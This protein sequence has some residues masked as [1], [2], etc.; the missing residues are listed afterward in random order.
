[1]R[2]RDFQRRLARGLRFTGLTMMAGSLTAAGLRSDIPAAIAAP[3]QALA[4][5]AAQ[6]LPAA[7]IA[8]S[9]GSTPAPILPSTPKPSEKAASRGGPLTF[10]MSGNLALGEHML[11]SSFAGSDTG[12]TGQSQTEGNAGILLQLSRRTGSTMTQLNV[13]LGVTSSGP[14]RLGFP[15]IT[16]ATPKVGLTYQAQPLGLLGQIPLGSTLSGFGVIVPFA[17]GDLTTFQGP[18]AIEDGLTAR[19]AGIRARKTTGSTI[20]EAGYMQAASESTPEREGLALFGFSHASGPLDETLEA[21]FENRKNAGADAPASGSAYQFRSD[22]GSALT[23]GSLTLRHQSD[24]FVALGGGVVSAD[25]F[26]DTSFRKTLSNSSLSFDGS[27]DKAG[28]GADQILTRRDSLTFTGSRGTVDYS[29]ALQDEHQLQAGAPAQWTGGVSGQ[30]QTE[31]FGT[32]ALFQG[33][34]QR[35]TGLAPG[36]NSQYGVSLQRQL[37]RLAFTY[38]G[39]VLNSTS[40]GAGSVILSNSINTSTQIG[41]RNTVSFGTSFTHTRTAASDALQ[42]TPL[43][44]FSRAISPAL[45]LG[46]N[47]GEQ[48]THDPINPSVDGHSRI[49][50][51][52]VDAPFSFG[53]GAVSGR[54]NPHLPATIAGSVVSVAGATNFVG[55]AASS[56]GISNVEVVLDES[57]VQR[58]DL[59]GHF[60][61]NLVSPG[62]HEVRIETASL[63]RGVTA[64]QPYAPIDVQGGQSAQVLFQIGSFGGIEGHVMGRTPSGDLYPISGAQIKLD[65]IT[66]VTTT[67]LGTFG[68][69]RLAPG[70]HTVAIDMASLPADASFPSSDA[71]KDVIVQNGQYTPVDFT[72]SALGSIAGK[73]VYDPAL[74]KDLANQGVTNAYVVAEPGEHAVIT[75]D[76]GSFLIDDLPAGTYNVNVDPETLPDGTGNESPP[77]S[78]EL[79]PGERHDGL[80]FTIGKEQKNIVFS[81]KATEDSEAAMMEIAHDRLPPGGETLVSVTAGEEATSVAAIA[82]GETHPLNYSRLT[83]RWEGEIDVPAAAKSGSYKIAA[84]IHGKRLLSASATLVVDPDAPAG[85]FR[86]HPRSIPSKA[87]TSWCT[88]A[89]WPPRTK[90]I[91]SFGRT[92]RRRLYPSRTRRIYSYSL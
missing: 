87:N 86:A 72:A 77:V 14:T 35:L 10:A 75:N 7:P 61:F 51:L 40:S 81:F 85:Y 4:Q 79:E 70:K 1:M 45:T 76:D 44:N 8:A 52:E 17:G 42:I 11:S 15:Q 73:L 82:F 74:G 31:L 56:N 50:N 18:I 9:A 66:T 6:A 36:S 41:L 59:L 62:H 43:V 48:F 28:E 83:S 60:Q 63:P 80:L 20:Y 68:F 5:I 22:F 37:G 54:P 32:N 12:A 78:V 91:A 67:A 58:T 16:Y 29:L 33:Q 53:T 84:T 46:L 89:F 30:L 92:V 39:Q 21:A 90:A 57:Q 24:G 88:R 34:L 23:Y 65:Q 38:N 19:L 13:P 69:G 3:I 71:V 27:M 26:A 2:G 25:D 49:I 47:V 55:S 64:D